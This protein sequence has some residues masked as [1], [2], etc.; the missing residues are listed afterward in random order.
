MSHNDG[1]EVSCEALLRELITLLEPELDEHVLRGVGHRLQGARESEGRW[2]EHIFAMPEGARGVIV[3]SVPLLDVIDRA[4]KR[5]HVEDEKRIAATTSQPTRSGIPYDTLYEAW[6][7]RWQNT[8]ER[9]G[10]ALWNAALVINQDDVEPLRA[11]DLDPYH[12]D[13]RID[14]FFLRLTGEVVRPPG[15]A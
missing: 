13:T 1:S 15:A 2:N 9:S 11:S 7:W 3:F 6:K 8:C 10:Q 14:A 12:D 5:L 4:Y